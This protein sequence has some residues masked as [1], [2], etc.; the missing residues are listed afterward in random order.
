MKPLSSHFLPFFAP[1]LV[2]TCVA[3]CCRDTVG[4]A[5]AF[6]ARREIFPPGPA[7]PVNTPDDG[8]A[9]VAGLE[10]SGV[11]VGVMSVDVLSPSVCC[12][13]IA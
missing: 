1:D 8:V 7:L 2:G 3:D 12:R 6:R 9:G 13:D 11:A 10:L 5:T 4:D